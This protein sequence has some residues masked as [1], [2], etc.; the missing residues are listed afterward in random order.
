MACLQYVT[1]VVHPVEQRRR[2]FFF[3]K[4]LHLSAKSRL[5]VMISEIFSN[6]CSDAEGRATR[7][8]RTGERQVAQYIDNHSTC[9]L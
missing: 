7:C 4:D 1:M 8:R 9:A 3:A 2:L 5:V 6:E